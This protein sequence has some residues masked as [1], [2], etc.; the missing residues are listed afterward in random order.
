VR[1]ELEKSCKTDGERGA[2]L[3]VVVRVVTSTGSDVPEDVTERFH[4]LGM[5]W[6]DHPSDEAGPIRKL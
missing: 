5:I 6:K 3:N 1:D 4:S 2:Q